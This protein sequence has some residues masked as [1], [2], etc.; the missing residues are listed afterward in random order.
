MQQLKLFDYDVENSKY[1][2]K[3]FSANGLCSD[4]ERIALEKK[5]IPILE[6]T[7]K[8]DRRSVSYQFNKKRPVHSWLKYKEGFSAELVSILLNEMQISEGSVIMDPFM[9]SG[10]TSLVC[11]MH[12]INSIGYDI[13]PLSEIV[14]QAKSNVLSYKISEIEALIETF[15]LLKM[16]ENYSKKTPFITI[17][18]SA[19]PE[20]NERF[21]QF[22]TDWISESH[23]SNEVKTL[24]KLCILNSLEKCS[25][26]AK[27]GQYL[28]WDSRSLK[29]INSNIERK[30]FGQ[31]LLPSHFCRETIGNI[32]ETI[33]GELNHVLSDIKI[34][35]SNAKKNLSSS[36]NFKKC[37]ALF[38]LPL[39]EGETI[40]GVITSPP[41]CNRYD[42]TRIYALELVYL[43]LNENDIKHLRQSL[44]SCT[45]ESNSK[46]SSLKHYYDS[47]NASNRFTYILNQINSNPYLQEVIKA[48]NERKI[49]GD[50]NNNGV[51]RM[52]EG[53]LSEL[54]FIF[55]ELHR[56]CKKGATVAI[57]NDNVR[58]GGEIIPIDFISTSF[59]EQFGF[60][61]LKVYC[62][63][64]QK[65]NSSQQMK[66][67]GRAALRKSITL[68]KK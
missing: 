42:Y 25:Y 37:S 3:N 62:L 51:T 31:K 1:I 21:I 12:E 63:K 32:Q 4:K 40:D 5:Y 54:A 49:C 46:I 8:F 68:W 38:E 2:N 28:R 22:T 64:Q 34:I 15:S 36:V 33:I 13:M 56:V 26:T 17:T 47:I 67:F 29:V 10:T 52:I 53:Y 35:Q 41:Y 11:Q 30:Q 23:Y 24:L 27:D 39:V 43:G 7:D 58:Y 6:V 44:L 59:A 61:P 55:A 19:Y 48:I 60:T 20:F 16:P 9:G 57:V 14:I 65:G 45:V 18:E 66:K 50:L